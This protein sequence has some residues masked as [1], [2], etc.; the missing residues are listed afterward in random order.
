MLGVFPPNSSRSYLIVTIK[1]EEK[2][3]TMR[4][5]RL[6]AEGR[7]NEACLLAQVRVINIVDHFWIHFFFT[8]PWSRF[9]SYKLEGR[10]VGS[11]LTFLSNE[12]SG[13]MLDT[14]LASL[15]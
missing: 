15:D 13:S 4:C 10:V 6:C 12:H 3:K 8:L 1:P 2:I 7:A 9:P 14:I 5:P 11:P